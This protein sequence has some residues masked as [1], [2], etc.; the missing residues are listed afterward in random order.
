MAI[1]RAL[2]NS[3]LNAVLS[4]YI[5]A[6]V[7]RGMSV[8]EAYKGLSN[9]VL[10]QYDIRRGIRYQTFLNYYREAKQLSDNVYSWSIAPKPGNKLVPFARYAKNIWG[11]KLMYPVQYR[12]VNETT[13]SEKIV[14]ISIYSEDRLTVKQVIEDANSKFT[15]QGYFGESESYKNLTGKWKIAETVPMPYLRQR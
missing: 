13:G 4:A 6:S 10:S 11:G 8:T 2:A 7:K 5:P 9:W 3:I 15:L 12:I 14:Y 1:T